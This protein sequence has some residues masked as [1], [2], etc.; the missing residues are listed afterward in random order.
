MKAVN[1]DGPLGELLAGLAQGDQIAPLPPP[2]GLTAT[3]RPYQQRGYAWLEFLT[4]WGLGACLADDMGLGKTV[5]TL[6]LLQRLRPVAAAAGGG[7]IAAGAAGLSDLTGR[8]LA[9]GNLA[10]RA[11]TAGHD[12]PRRGAR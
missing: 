3:L 12:P 7:R 5:Q 6:A 4:R 10:L 8:Q 1:A 9:Q 11:A 2:P